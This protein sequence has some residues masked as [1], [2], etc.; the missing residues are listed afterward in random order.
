MTL[1]WRSE[2]AMKRRCSWWRAL[3]GESAARAKPVMDACLYNYYVTQVA[4]Y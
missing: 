1:L 3:Q 4:T 2:R